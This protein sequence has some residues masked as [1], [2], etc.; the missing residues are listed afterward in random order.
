VAFKLWLRRDDGRIT[1][2]SDPRHSPGAAWPCT[3]AVRL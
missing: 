3:A 2:R 1:I